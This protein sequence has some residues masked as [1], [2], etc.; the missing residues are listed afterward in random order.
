MRVLPEATGTVTQPGETP[1]RPG[2]RQSLKVLTE[3]ESQIRGYEK[4]HFAVGQESEVRSGDDGLGLAGNIHTLTQH[5]PVFRSLI[6]PG[7]SEHGL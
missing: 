3:E 2:Y 7:A 6:R 5:C 1:G 4:G